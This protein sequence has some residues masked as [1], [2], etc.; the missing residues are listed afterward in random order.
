MSADDWRALAPPKIEKGA[1]WAVKEEVGRKF[2]RVLGP[3][4]EDTMPRAN[5]VKAVRFTG[6]VQAIRDGVAYI[7]YQGRI[8]GSHET[9]S[10]RGFCHGQADLAGTARYDV[11]TGQMLAL[12]WVFDGTFRDV[13]PHDEARKYSGVA[14]WRGKES[15]R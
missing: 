5:E 14:E 10:N 15:G 9:Q 8:A 11:K 1:E 7:G 2:C 12:V 3:G 13:A 4:N 6:R